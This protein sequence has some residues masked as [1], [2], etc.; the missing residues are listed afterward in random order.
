MTRS[1]TESEEG[2]EIAWLTAHDL[3]EAL[4][5]IKPDV[6]E[7]YARMVLR[8]DRNEK[9]VRRGE[10]VEDR[11]SDEE[12][13]LHAVMLAEEVRRAAARMRGLSGCLEVIRCSGKMAK[14]LVDGAWLDARWKS[15][16]PGV[17]DPFDPDPW[18]DA[19]HLELRSIM[20]ESIRERASV[21]IRPQRGHAPSD[22]T[23]RRALPPFAGSIHAPELMSAPRLFFLAAPL[24]AVR[25]AARYLRREPK[26]WMSVDVEAGAWRIAVKVHNSLV[27]H[28]PPSRTLRRLRQALGPISGV[29]LDIDMESSEEVRVHYEISLRDLRFTTCEVQP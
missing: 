8:D 26:A 23:V 28:A 3:K 24:E 2:R 1:R 6:L 10:D 21:Q 7:T 11:A 29:S 18:I 22:Y 12:R 13:I 14:G 17:D 27:G 25:N 16:P 20:D 15:W 19:I 4:A 5:E 9:R